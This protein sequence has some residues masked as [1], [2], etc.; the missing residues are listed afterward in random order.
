[1]YYKN[2]V[3]V[4]YVKI[5]QWVDKI[6]VSSNRFDKILIGISLVLLKSIPI[7]KC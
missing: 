2:N 4:K 6:S 3:P 1:M 7:T 5:H